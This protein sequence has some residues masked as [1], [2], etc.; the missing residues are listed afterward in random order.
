MK[1]KLRR[2]SVNIEKIL[3][4]LRSG[5]TI[6]ALLDEL[7]HLR[8]AN[9]NNIVTANLEYRKLWGSWW[10]CSPISTNTECSD[11]MGMISFLTLLPGRIRL[12]NPKT[13][14]QL[15]QWQ[16]STSP[17]PKKF[18]QPPNANWKMI[19]CLHETWN[20]NYCCHVLRNA[21]EGKRCDPIQTTSR[22]G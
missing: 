22:L 6:S 10:K 12:I 18:K 8:P 17:K 3:E 15:I 20:N 2:Y 19:G 13:K 11:K 7:P 1:Y 21:S 5:L 9:V 16:Y 14:Q 4:K